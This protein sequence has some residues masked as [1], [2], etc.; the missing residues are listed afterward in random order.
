MTGK[1][2]QSIQNWNAILDEGEP[3]IVTS[4]VSKNISY[5]FNAEML[6]DVARKNEPIYEVVAS[7]MRHPSA[8]GDIL[9]TG[10]ILF[11]IND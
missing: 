5:Y 10:H 7:W 1:R 4:V 9:T 11:G 6:S 3:K 8:I 2:R